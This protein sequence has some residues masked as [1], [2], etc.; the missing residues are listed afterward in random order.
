MKGYSYLKKAIQILEAEGTD[1]YK[2]NVMNLLLP[3]IAEKNKT[4]EP[5]MRAAIKK[6]FKS[7]DKSDPLVR[8]LF[9]D[10]FSHGKEYPSVC[11]FL[12]RVANFIITA[13]R[14]R[15]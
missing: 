3:K 7:V 1:K 15:E 11:I 14:D 5:A 10:I 8:E 6:G 13:K 12:I 2:G 9:E 4:P